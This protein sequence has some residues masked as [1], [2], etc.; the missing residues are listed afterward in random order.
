MAT[1]SRGEIPTEFSGSADGMDDLITQSEA[2]K[3]LG[4]TVEAITASIRRGRLSV[5][6]LFGRRL[7]HRSEVEKLEDKRGWPKGKPRKEGG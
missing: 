7:V 5:V 2:A 3:M 4:V 1:K 6:E